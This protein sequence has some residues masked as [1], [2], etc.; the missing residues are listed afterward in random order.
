MLTSAVRI[1]QEYLKKKGLYAGKIDGDRGPKTHAAAA[2]LLDARKGELAG[3]PAG[4]SDKRKAVAAYQLHI[5]EEGIDVGAIDG[6]WGT[7]TDAGHEALE[8]KREFGQPLLWRDETPGTANPH[9]WPADG[10]GQSALIAFYGQPGNAQ[11]TAGKVTCPWPLKLDWDRSVV[12]T[13][14]SCHEKV[15]ASLQ[16]VLEAVA[17]KYAGDE[18]E[19]LGL[20]IYGGCFNK[21][22]KRGGSTWSTHAWGVALDFDPSRNRLKWGRDRARFARPEYDAWWDCWEAEGWLSL[23][24]ARNFDWMHVQAVKLP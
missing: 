3:D 7:R 4:W 2:A 14:I 21:R 8:E 17:A 23:G 9:G 11:C 24:R 12:V 22:K 10:A 6:L 5:T 15:A 1:L 19:A 20:D 13:R 16:R 18:I